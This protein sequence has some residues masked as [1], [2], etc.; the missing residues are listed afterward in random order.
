MGSQFG[1][2]EKSRGNYTIRL[3]CYLFCGQTLFLIIVVQDCFNDPS[4]RLYAEIVWNHYRDRF[5]R[6]EFWYWCPSN[7]G[8]DW[9]FY[10]DA[11]ANPDSGRLGVVNFV[12]TWIWPILLGFAAHANTLIL[13]SLPAYH[14][15][16]ALHILHGL[17]DNDDSQSQLK[18]WEQLIRPLM[19]EWK[20]V[21]VLTTLTSGYV[22]HSC[23]C[24]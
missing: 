3:V 22:S 18:A 20:T 13:L 12:F 1:W 16:R 19:E 10:D 23:L 24:L 2:F 11:R 14:R 15:G 9:A 8:S 21:S 5:D 4:S 7:E 17:S 6:S